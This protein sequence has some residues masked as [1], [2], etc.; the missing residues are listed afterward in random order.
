MMRKMLCMLAV[1]VWPLG[2]GGCE[3][4]D[5]GFSLGSDSQEHYETTQAWD[6]QS[7]DPPS[8]GPIAP[9]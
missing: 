5:L 9:Y 8:R 1:A 6:G 7:G 2:L 3:G 4:Y